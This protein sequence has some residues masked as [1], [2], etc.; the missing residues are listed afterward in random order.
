[1][2]IKAKL[3]GA[4]ATEADGYKIDG[5]EDDSRPRAENGKIDIVINTYTSLLLAQHTY[6]LST[7]T[8]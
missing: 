4:D 7:L 1:M 5:S 2:F 3:D 8:I 6:C